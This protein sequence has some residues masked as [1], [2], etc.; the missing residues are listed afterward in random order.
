MGLN[1]KRSDIFPPGTVVKTYG[2]L[3]ER[4]RGNKPSGTVL[5]EATVDARGNLSFP[6]L[7]EGQFEL[8]AEVGGVEMNLHAGSEN[9]VPLTTTPAQLAKGAGLMFARGAVLSGTVS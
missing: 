3:L 5:A 2:P 7:G 9:F 8:W 6:T 1:V 4:R